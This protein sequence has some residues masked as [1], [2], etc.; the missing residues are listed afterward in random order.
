MKKLLSHRFLCILLIFAVVFGGYGAYL[1]IAGDCYTL[2]ANYNPSYF[3]ESTE[4]F[5]GE[6]G[7]RTESALFEV[8]G[9]RIH[10]SSVSAKVKARGR[11]EEQVELRVVCRSGSG[12]VRSTR[13]SRRLLKA[14]PAD[15]ITNNLY[16]DIYIVLSVTTLLL[17]V[18]YV[19]CFLSAVK[20]RRFSYDTIFFL[21]IVLFF[22]VLLALWGSASVYSFLQYGT[23]S[24]Q[25][26]YEVNGNLM[27]M[28]T[29]ASLPVM[30][31]FVLSVSVSNIV[32]MRRE[33]FRPT[34][35]LGIITSVVMLGGLAV[36]AVLYVM[37]RN[38]D[39]TVLKVAYSVLTSLY[40]LFEILLASSI[41]YGVYTSK[42]TPS[43]DKDYIIILG[44]MIKPDGTLYPLI[45]GRVDKAVEFYR[46]QLEKTGKQAYFI[47]SG[48]QGDDEIMPEAEAM[49]NYL[50]TQG[51]PEDRILPERKSTTTKE[52]MLFSA[53]I[54]REHGEK[55]EIIFSTTSYHVFRSGAIAY[56]N[57]MNIDGIGSKTKWY[58][59]PNAFLR[60]VAGIFVNQPKKQILITLLIALAAGF[61][62]FAYSLL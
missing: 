33:G 41:L 3:L 51:I 48:G 21:S 32:L 59:W 39:M 23:T 2:H 1:L 35:A 52:N 13:M 27:T 10:R 38:Y 58:F 43:F 11:G 54:I 25:I 61:G 7:E 26:V 22:A 34:N 45:R 15:V 49:K 12:D 40:I 16:D 37:N 14:G 31:L 53:D 30:L 9:I 4:V 50:L 18:Y 17:L 36:I 24:T 5:F 42:H 29:V 28:L 6:N 60:E 47:P 8:Q 62:S 44:C 55:P 20:T 56:S 19:Y 57:G 46:K